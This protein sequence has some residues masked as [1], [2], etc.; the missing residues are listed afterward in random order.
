VRTHRYRITISG[1]LGDIGREA[2]GEFRVEPNGNDTILVA[3]LDQ[4]ALYGALNRIL[5]LGFELL[6][7]KRVTDEVSA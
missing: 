7:L 3:D 5:T 1:K 6:A 4:A 2:F